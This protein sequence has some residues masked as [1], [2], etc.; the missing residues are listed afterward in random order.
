MQEWTGH[1]PWLASAVFFSPRLYRA[2]STTRSHCLYT[3]QASA[4]G[5]LFL[6]SCRIRR[7][8]GRESVKNRLEQLGPSPMLGI[9]LSKTLWPK[10]G[11]IC[12]QFGLF[13]CQHNIALFIFLHWEK[14]SCVI[15]EHHYSNTATKLWEVRPRAHKLPFRTNFPCKKKSFKNISATEASTG[16]RKAHKLTYI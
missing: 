5:G 14:R 7:R 2:V 9:G 16:W 1:I 10:H 15:A 3:R 8:M 12:G 13:W 4:P 11:A 6:S